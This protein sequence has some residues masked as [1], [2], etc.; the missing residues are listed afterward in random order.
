MA[1]ERLAA[2]DALEHVLALQTDHSLAH[3]ALA[4]LLFQEVEHVGRDTPDLLKAAWEGPIGQHLR[5]GLDLRR[6]CSRPI[7]WF[8]RRKR[9]SSRV[10]LAGCHRRYCAD[11]SS[12]G[13]LDEMVPDE[14]RFAYYVTYGLLQDKWEDTIKW[15]EEA[16]VPAFR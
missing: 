7:S 2:R 14:Y 8:Y 15:W 5:S 3:L 9:R 16:F 12:A 1:R 6:L 10:L 13:C 4:W 11:Y